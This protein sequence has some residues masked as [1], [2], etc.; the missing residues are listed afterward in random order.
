MILLLFSV[1]SWGWQGISTELSSKCNQIAISSVQ[2]LS[3]VSLQP[4]ESQHAR[5]P[6]PSPIPRVYSNSC[7][8]SQWCHPTDILSSVI[9]FSSFLQS[10]PAPESFPMSQLLAWGGQSIGASALASCLPM[11]TQDWSPL[12][13]TGW[14]SLQSYHPGNRDF[15]GSCKFGW[16]GEEGPGNVL[17]GDRTF[18]GAPK[19][20]SPHCSQGCQLAP[21]HIAGKTKRMRLAPS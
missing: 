17:S 9:P 15:P 19:D 1:T 6:C 11:N 2:L 20:V 16:C 8:S 21:W 3:R 10:L 18:N 4:H 12:E 13:W 14:I 7:P 5:S